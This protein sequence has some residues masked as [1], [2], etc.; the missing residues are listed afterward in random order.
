METRYFDLHVFI[1]RNQ[2]Y[3]FGV[4]MEVP[5]GTD[6]QDDEVIEF[7]VKDNRFTE[8]GDAQM[9]DTV[10]EISEEEFNAIY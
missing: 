3:S 4:K 8:D 10:D 9:V 6:I 1:K 2:G 7:A 5:I